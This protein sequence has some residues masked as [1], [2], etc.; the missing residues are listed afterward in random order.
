MQKFFWVPD[1]QF[2]NVESEEYCFYP[3]GRWKFLIVVCATAVTH[4]LINISEN[5]DKK[6][7]SEKMIK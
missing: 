3:I 1:L 6:N 4:V 7:I 5:S 2:W